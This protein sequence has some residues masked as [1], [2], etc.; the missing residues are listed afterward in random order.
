MLSIRL[1]PRTS[2]HH[3]TILADTKC[4]SGNGNLFSAG[5]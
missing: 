4:F 5:A 2:S 3:A 1:T